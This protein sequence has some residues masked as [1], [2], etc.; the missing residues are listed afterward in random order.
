MKYIII[1][2]KQFI[3]IVHTYDM[4]PV[5]EGTLALYTFQD[6]QPATLD[7]FI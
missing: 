1:Y 6:S 7:R 5:Q 4:V 2:Y 3:A